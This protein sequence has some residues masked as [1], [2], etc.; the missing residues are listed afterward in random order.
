[1]YRDFFQGL[2]DILRDSHKFIKTLKV[3]PSTRNWWN[4]PSGYTGFR[5][6]ASLSQK[7]AGVKVYVD[8]QLFEELAKNQAEIAAQFGESLDW[9]LLKDD[10][11]SQ[12][13]LIWLGEVQEND[14]TFAEIQ[15]WM[16]TNLLK[17][18]QVF[19]PYLEKLR[20]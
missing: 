6:R 4:F 5:Y 17:F 3:S 7:Q 20:G 15:G 11:Y 10:R 19:S 12:I 9:K 13:E 8:H 18:K 16:V 1:M 14:D 2:V